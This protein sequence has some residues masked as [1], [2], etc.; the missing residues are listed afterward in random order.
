MKKLLILCVG[1]AGVAALVWRLRTPDLPHYAPSY[2]EYAYVSNGKSNTVS[3]LDLTP[4]PYP[5][6]N[7]IRT[8]RVGSN[9]T[10]VAANGKKNEIYVVNTESNN[11]SVID[12]ER[13]QVAATIG[14]H[15]APYF[16]SVSEDG[17]R[18]YV[19]NSGSANVSVLDL[20]AR[21]VVANVRVGAAPGL[22]DR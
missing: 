13:N 3:V 4:R 6:F 16:I 20:E 22:S 5:R 10:G 11:V 15:R 9:P 1:V 19:A 8:I 21:Q 17:K 2:R 14:V 12:A 18:G 7:V